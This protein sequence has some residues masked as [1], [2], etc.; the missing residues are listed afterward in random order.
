MTEAKARPGLAV[1]ARTWPAGG[2]DGRAAS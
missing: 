1:G 2:N